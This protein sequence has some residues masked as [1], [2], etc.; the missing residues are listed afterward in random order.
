MPR[1][2]LQLLSFAVTANLNPFNIFGSEFTSSTAALIATFAASPIVEFNLKTAPI[3]IMDGLEVMFWQEPLE[4]REKMRGRTE[5]TVHF[6]SMKLGSI[7][8]ITRA[9]LSQNFG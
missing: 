3:L 8:V 9:S 4:N 7:W 2:P 6:I 5:R 1:N